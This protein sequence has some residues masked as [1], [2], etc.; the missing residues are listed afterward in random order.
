VGNIGRN[1]ERGSTISHV[2]IIAEAQTVG[3][4]LEVTLRDQGYRLTLVESYEEFSDLWPRP[5]GIGVDM[6]IATN[7]SLSPA[8]ILQIVPGIKVQYPR[9]RILV[10]SGYGPREFVSALMQEGIDAFLSIPWIEAELLSAVADLLPVP[11]S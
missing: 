8:R 6:V 10:L 9:S 3:V 5:G 4:C 1:Q 7:T 2:V 11:V